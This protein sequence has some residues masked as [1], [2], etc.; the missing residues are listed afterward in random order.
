MTHSAT[1]QANLITLAI[2]AIV[3][4]RFLMRELRA[5]VVRARTLWIRPA[6]LVVLTALLASTAFILPYGDRALT[7]FALA[8]GAVVGA[9]TGALV[10]RSTR[11][12]PAGEPNAIRAHGSWVTAAIWIVALALRF[13]VRYALSPAD[14]QSP[15]GQAQFSALNAGLIALVAAAFVVVAAGFHRAIAAAGATNAPAERRL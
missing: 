14:P 4:V 9:V 3:V 13:A 1:T 7:V 12:E 11:F 15:A 10:V 6:V 8:G 2:I 5:R